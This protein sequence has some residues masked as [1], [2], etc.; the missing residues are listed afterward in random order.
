V[1]VVS[2]LPFVA[3]NIPFFPSGKVVILDSIHYS[4]QKERKRP[5]LSTGKYSLLSSGGKHFDVGFGD[6]L[7]SMVIENNKMRIKC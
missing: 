2:P 7:S 3:R 1:R 4:C 5:P 6:V